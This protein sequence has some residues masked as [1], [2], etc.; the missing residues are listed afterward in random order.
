M[1]SQPQR[2][3]L[4]ARLRRDRDANSGSG[5][6]SRAG[7]LTRRPAGMDDPPASYGQEQL[8]F[9]D[10]FAPGG[11][12]YNLL[13]AIRIGGPLDVTALCRATQAVLTRH[14]ALRTRLVPGAD[15]RP[16]QMIDLPPQGVVDVLDHGVGGDEAWSRLTSL[17]A[18]ELA[19]PFDLVQGPLTRVHLIR[20]ADADHMLLVTVHHAIF[21]GFSAGVLVRD[22]AALYAAEVTGEP[23]GLAELPVQF[24]DYAWWE[25]QRLQGNVLE[26][27]EAYWRRTLEG[28]ELLRLPTDRP[29]PPVDSSAGG[30]V[31]TTFGGDLL[32]G[33]Q[34][35]SRREG[36][37]LFVT[38]MAA[39]QALLF[40]YTGQ[41]D[42][43]VG[44]TTAN[45]SRAALEPVIGFLVN[46][47]PIRCD[48]SGDPPF[49]EVV[50]RVR[51][52]TVGAYAHQDLPFGKIVEALRAERDASR[53][54]I[55]QLTFNLA[56]VPHVAVTAAEVT[57]ALADKL[58]DAGTAK[59][60]LD[61]LAEARG[62]GL[63]VEATYTSAL[64]DEETIRRL[65]GH[66]EVLLRGVAADPSARLSTLPVLTETECRQELTGWND[67]TRE[68]P[69][70][71]VHEAFE[72]QVSRT[73]DAIAAE[74]EGE[75]VSYAELNWQA[76]Q[77]A[78]RLRAA[79]I[80]PEV[81][82]AVCL[83]AS[84]RRLAA[85][86]GIWKAGGG[87]VPVS[88]ELP[89]RRMS[90]MLADS[91]AALLLTDS[92]ALTA[93]GALAGLPPGSATVLSLDAEQPAISA[94]DGTGLDQPGATAGNVAYVIYTSGSTGQ[95]KGVVVE[96]RQVTNF[97]RAQI[98]RWQVG[99]ADV[100]L[101]SHS[102]SF[103]ASVQDL[104]MPLV[105]G[106][107]VVLASDETLRSPP[108][109]AALIMSRGVTCLL[110]TPAALSLLGDREFP[111]MRLLSLG[112]EVFP[113]E[114]ARRWIRPGL[115]LSNEYGPTEATVTALSMRID[116]A[117][118]L[119]PPIGRPL[120]NY[121][122]YVL[123]PDLNPVPAGIT[124]ELHIGGAGVARGYL[125]RP[126]LTRERFIPDPFRPDPTTR[127]Y[128]TGDLVRRRGDGTIVFLGRADHQVKIHGLRIELGEIEAALAAHPAVAQAV[129]AVVTSP[130]GDP[131]LAGYVRLKSVSPPGDPGPTGPAELRAFLAS[132]LPAYM[133]P[134][135]LVSVEAFPLNSSGKI[136]HHA[137]PAPGHQDAAREHVAPATYLETVLTGLY[138]TVLQSGPV[139]A[140][141]SFFDLGGSSLQVMRLVDLISRDLGVDA[142]VAT[143]FLHPAP[144]QLA[145]RIDALRSGIGEP[146]AHDSL[147]ELANGV[148]ELPLLLIHAVG[149]TVFPYAQLAAEL[150][151]VFRVRGLEA[152]GLGPDGVTAAT[153][154][155]LAEDYSERLLAVQ[156]D[157]PYRLA[158]WSMG[159][160][161]AFEVARRLERAG[162]QVASLVLLDAPFA[163]PDRAAPGQ[164]ELAGRFLA[165]AARSL[166]WDA[167]PLPDPAAST[168]DEQLAWLAGRLDGG[169][170]GR[171]DGGGDT[172]GG[173]TDGGT[174][175][176]AAAE[177]TALKAGAAGAGASG[178]AARLRRRFEVFGAHVQLL[179]G[180]ESQV[181][182][183]RAPTLIVSA[184]ASPNAPAAA[185]WPRVL[186]GPVTTQPVAGDHYTFLRPPLVTEVAA[187]ILKWHDGS[188]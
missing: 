24:A 134:A 165:D 86:L 34:E 112:G 160:V 94:L 50:A 104:Y 84:L 63:W 140:T 110:T 174:S 163:M 113:A 75:R 72:A 25:R 8:W 164:A 23:S 175:A 93:D 11:T 17:A 77:I 41:A 172:D 95:P 54:P 43:V 127:L 186:A 37:T 143:I 188:G 3:A 80:G 126:E 49:T 114:L 147:I 56:G 99:P 26:E 30:Q 98:F 61:V 142:G 38:L 42:L 57:F 70:T 97:L 119:P 52:A 74:F 60:D 66:F 59:F 150:S 55:T 10:R 118:P 88:P 168:A 44:T 68:F 53:A 21:D 130:S 117:T 14:E 115:Q 36:T 28:S 1:L 101:M 7:R 111:R 92:P 141:D 146:A 120:A 154:A 69:V 177:V 81:L 158:G 135:H 65:L 149:G 182:A 106:A 91:G 166:G 128:K 139:G 145:P 129:V 31:T 148:G 137:L 157:G 90:F 71:T 133:I 32:P 27:L 85:L 83:P 152:P 185:H 40:R 171:R 151:G 76:N 51:E 184:A 62:D 45:R 46:T 89:A 181:P 122:A 162:H 132:T 179:A 155:A 22:L 48:L 180:Y 102:L 100:V 9:L 176:G 131:Q 178:V 78:R 73:P 18:G 116:D 169:P 103:D 16:V 33:L 67:T 5:E 156:P 87:Y 39:F 153:L 136:D 12:T 2:A 19:R 109:L 29:R 82:V 170:G 124:G 183:V 64:F 187:S 20:L 35:L 167:T 58:V 108:R 15:S 161:I 4:A 144:R 96:H 107:Q 79:G 123:D 138:E 13:C 125:N 105:C 159:G 6:D 47:L 121:Q 173:D